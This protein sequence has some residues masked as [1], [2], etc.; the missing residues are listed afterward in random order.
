[1]GNGRFSEKLAYKEWFLFNVGQRIH[2]N[3]LESV[4]III[5][6]VLISGIKYP[7]VAV[8]AGGA[9]V[10]ARIIYH[11]GYETKGPSGRVAGFIISQLS[12]IVLFVVSILSPLKMA[13]VY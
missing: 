7:W 13:G 9:Y 5:C 2:Y 4:T 11:I 1:M 8:A 3:Y 6:W 10:I 12:S